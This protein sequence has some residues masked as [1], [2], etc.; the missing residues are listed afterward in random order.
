M[1]MLMVAGFLGSGKTTFVINLAGKLVAEG[2]KVAILVNE[3]G[4]IGIDG[5]LMRQLDM[6]VWE[7]MG[8]CVCC[9]LAASLPE[10][11]VQVRNDYHP[12][13]VLLEPSGSAE[14]HKVLAA[15]SAV[16]IF[17][18]ENSRTVVLVDVPRLPMLREIIM[19]LI[20]AQITNADFVALNKMDDASPQ[21]MKEAEAFVREL[22]P[23]APV[24][25]CSG[26]EGIPMEWVKKITP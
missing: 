16:A 1:K 19:P 10:T 26:R 24:F 22:N 9:T 17:R 13:L 7:L 25:S 5:Q 15:L 23:H 14:T 4:E 18:P 6:N 8:G 2:K 3:I 12:D 21:E 20:S 11:L